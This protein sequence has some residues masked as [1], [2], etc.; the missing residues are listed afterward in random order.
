MADASMRPPP[1]L[2]GAGEAERESAAEKNKRR[3]APL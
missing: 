2:G 3:A 1:E